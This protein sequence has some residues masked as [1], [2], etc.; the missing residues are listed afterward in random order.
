[1]KRFLLPIAIVTFLFSGMTAQ[2]QP[3]IDLV[4]DLEN[5]DSNPLN[6]TGCTLALPNPDDRMY[7]HSGVCSAT[8]PNLLPEDCQD[9][10]WV[11]EHVVGNWGED[12]GVGEMTETSPGVWEISIDVA[13]YYSDPATLSADPWNNGAQPIPFPTG[14]TAYSMGFV[15]RNQTGD[16]GGI[17]GGCTDFFIFDLDQGNTSVNVGINDPQTEIPDTVFNVATA[18]KERVSV[19]VKD[20]YP[21]PFNNEVKIAYD[22]EEYTSDISIQIHDITGR[23]VKTLYQGAHQ[24]GAHSIVWDGNTQTG[25]AVQQGMY[26]Y[27]ITTPSQKISGKI[28]KA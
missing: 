9:H 21:N 23:V 2:A 16:I 1:M 7:V 17:T 6:V 22:V 5:F 27:T 10:N 11:W 28:M 15:F 18:I 19:T 20:T 24:S 25:E 4:I 13:T 3:F 26:F 14:G 8:S 12:D